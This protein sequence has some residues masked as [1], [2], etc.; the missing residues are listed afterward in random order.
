MKRLQV[1][2]GVTTGGGVFITPLHPS[3]ERAPQ[4]R[5]AFEAIKKAEPEVTGMVWLA[6]VVCLHAIRIP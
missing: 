5:G 3:A 4:G 1:S 2:S 6:S